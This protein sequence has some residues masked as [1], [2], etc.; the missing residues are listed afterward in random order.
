MNQENPD[1]RYSEKCMN[2]RA[3]VLSILLKRFGKEWDNKTVYSC[4]DELMSL[5]KE[6]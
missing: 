2:M 3:E 6:C 4:A 1:S 5:M